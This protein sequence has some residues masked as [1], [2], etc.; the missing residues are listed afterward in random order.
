MTQQYLFQVQRIV[1]DAVAKAEEQEIK[2]PADAYVTV[3]KEA[4]E[5]IIAARM[6]ADPDAPS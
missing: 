1:A 6:D 5:K 2:L 4:V 3:L